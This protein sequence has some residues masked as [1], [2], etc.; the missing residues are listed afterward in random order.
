MQG[1]DISTCRLR[2]FVVLKGWGSGV[3]GL[4]VRSFKDLR[5]LEFGV[6]GLVCRL[7]HGNNGTVSVR[8]PK[9]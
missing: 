5:G 7:R 4:R 9:P 6:P 1:Q 8:N 3:Q 2:L